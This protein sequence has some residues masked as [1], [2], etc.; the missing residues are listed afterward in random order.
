MDYINQAKA[1]ISKHNLQK[2]V[3]IL[4]DYW[5][6]NPTIIGHGFSHVLKVAVEAYN[7]AIENNM[8]NPVNYFLAGLYHDIY[9]PAEGADGSEQHHD[10][11]AKIIRDLL[12][13]EAV[14][15]EDID[16]ISEMID[17]DLGGEVKKSQIVFSVADKVSH[18]TILTDSYVWA[19]N[20]FLKKNG[21]PA[22]YTNHLVTLYAFFI[23]QRKAWE[24]FMKHPVKGTER[25]IK[26]YLD[27]IQITKDAY[28]K[29][30]KGEHFFDYIEKSVV[31]ARDLEIEF[32][33]EFG[34]TEESIR[35]IMKNYY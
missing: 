21:K 20:N 27:I 24:I 29:D 28:E 32:L 2:Y 30:K 16:I 13:K 12:S 11:S 10:E 26:S 19:S 6:V 31:R 25:A 14:R 4:L 18:D 3:D 33:K 34:R 7:L 17:I 22:K 5:E 15:S 8:D 1:I 23:Y 35:K 9:R